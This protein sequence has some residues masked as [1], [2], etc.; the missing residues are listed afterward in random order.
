MT[1]KANAYDIT[2]ELVVFISLTAFTAWMTVLIKKKTPS[3]NPKFFTSTRSRT[4]F[5]ILCDHQIL[6]SP[7][8]D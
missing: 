5:T 6:Y 7:G 3:G 2:T 4:Q 8:V 1:S